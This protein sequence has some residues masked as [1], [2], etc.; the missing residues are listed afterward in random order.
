MNWNFNPKIPPAVFL[1]GIAAVVSQSPASAASV[2]EPKLKTCA[3]S[4]EHTTSGNRV[5]LRRGYPNEI[6]GYAH[7]IRLTITRD[8]M[9][10]AVEA[11]IER[12]D[13]VHRLNT[14]DL[15][16]ERQILDPVFHQ[17]HREYSWSH[18]AHELIVEAKR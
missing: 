12:D 5:F 17:D 10:R 16:N 8:T 2:H 15:F 4:V 14:S 6:N 13:V 11:K 1:I 3:H 7:T 18:N 9:G